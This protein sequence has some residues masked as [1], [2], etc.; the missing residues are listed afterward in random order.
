MVNAIEDVCEANKTMSK[1]MRKKQE[2]PPQNKGNLQSSDVSD[3]FLHSTFRRRDGI[4]SFSKNFNFSNI[5]PL[6]AVNM[7]KGRQ[8]GPKIISDFT[9]QKPQNSN[10]SDDILNRL[11]NTVTNL[12]RS[13][14]S[15]NRS[16][17]KPSFERK[18]KLTQKGSFTLWLD[19]LTSELRTIDYID[20]LKNSC[21]LEETY[22]FSESNKRK[23]LVKELIISHL[24]EHHHKKVINISE[25]KDIISKIKEFRLAE[26][27]VTASSVKARLYNLKIKTNESA[28][29]FIDRFDTVVT[30]YE[31]YGDMV[32]LSEEEKRSAFYH[33]VS[34]RYKEIRTAN[35]IM[36]V[37]T[38]AEMSLDDIKAYLINL[39][40]ENNQSINQFQRKTTSE[41]RAN[42]VTKSTEPK[43]EKCFRC[44]REGHRAA[45]CPL[46]EY[47][48]WYCFY[49]QAVRN[50]KGDQCPNKD[51]PKDGYVGKLNKNFRD[52]DVKKEKSQSKFRDNSKVSK[53]QAKSKASGSKG[54]KAQKIKAMLTSEDSGATEHIV[55]KGFILKDFK[56]SNREMRVKLTGV[57]AAKDISHNLLS[58]RRF[59]DA[60]LGIYLDDTRLKI[61]DRETKEELLIGEYKKPNWVIDLEV[62]SNTTGCTNQRNIY[63][64]TAHMVNLEEFI[65]QSQTDI[66]EIQE[67]LHSDVAIE[68]R[69]S[70]ITKS[71]IG[72]EKEYE[73]N[74]E[75]ETTD[76]NSDDNQRL[77]D[78]I[79]SYELNVGAKIDKGLLWH[80]KLG[81]KSLK[82]LKQL[83]KSEA[84]LSDVHF[85]DNILDCEVCKLA[86]ME[87][88]P[89]PEIRVRATKPLER[90][91]VDTMGPIKPESYPGGNKFIVVIVDDYT[92]Y[93]KAYSAKTKDQA[94]E[95][96]EEFL[97]HTRNILG[98]NE[99]V[100][101]V[102]SDNG[103]EFT[104]GH[105]SEVVKSENAEN[106]FSPP[107]T[108]ELN[109]TAERFNKTLQWLIRALM[110]DSG[111]PK[112]M[113]SLASDVAT[114]VYNRTPHSGINF[115]TPLQRMDQRLKSHIDKIRRFGCLAYTRVPIPES[116]FSERAVK[117]VLVGY[118]KSGYILWQYETGKFVISRHA[119]FNE[120]IVYRDIK[121]IRKFSQESNHSKNFESHLEFESEKKDLETQNIPEETVKPHRGRP[122]KRRETQT[123]DCK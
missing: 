26:T 110:I 108:P 100:C 103:T 107:H 77:L 104:G 11:N 6:N 25:P 9:F 109:G 28:S 87:R 38:K 57:I 74:P 29:E 94:G 99:K 4:G 90:L 34:E 83:Q 24:D 64:C 31:N 13:V 69:D 32:P 67:E 93:S 88:L 95:C 46:R 21:D 91:H 40:V 51:N 117:T 97:K 35:S 52:R 78:E 17:V 58:L 48:L 66:S 102:R 12:A 42:V 23:M 5:P 19:S 47:N 70:E 65:Q 71:E 80:M 62:Q 98:K 122:K 119:K 36:R 10:N 54:K 85:K 115:E 39:Q 22:G 63:S 20:V 14:D 45:G 8:S 112:S 89:S 84:I 33:A 92:K 81:H 111:L 68:I 118:T 15:G 123:I 79:M 43:A 114:N 105:F 76:A 59:A 27:N 37:T 75:K 101:Y 50:H 72:R 86:K 56:K 82:Y 16:R 30:E 113:W 3:S 120:K 106:E 60:G 1:E 61:F 2:G 96:L 121:N 116:K 55:R 7:D 44:N 73:L 53:N 18:Y 49:C 41:V